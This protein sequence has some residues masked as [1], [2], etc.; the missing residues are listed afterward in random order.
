MREQ[1]PFFRDRDEQT[2]AIIGEEAVNADLDGEY[3]KPY[4][5]LTQKRL[6]K[7]LFSAHVCLSY[8]FWP[9]GPAH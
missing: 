5:V 2:Q 6:Y 7:D 9:V 1:Y 8:G 4:A 3:Q